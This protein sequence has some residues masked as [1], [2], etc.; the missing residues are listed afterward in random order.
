VQEEKALL[1]DISEKERVDSDISECSDDKTEREIGLV[2]PKQGKRKKLARL[3]FSDAKGVVT[4]SDDCRNIDGDQAPTNCFLEMKGNVMQIK[5][6]YFS[7]MI[8]K[9]QGTSILPNSQFGHIISITTSINNILASNFKRPIEESNLLID[10]EINSDCIGQHIITYQ[11]VDDNILS[12]LKLS[13]MFTLDSI[14][15]WVALLVLNLVHTWSKGD[16][17]CVIILDLIIRDQD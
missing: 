13:Q 9:V 5:D 2:V 10:H 16:T 4:L 6:M 3:D 12:K 17:N 15:M 7:S 11:E 1:A 8:N 14:F